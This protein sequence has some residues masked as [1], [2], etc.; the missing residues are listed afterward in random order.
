[1]KKIISLY[2]T[3]ILIFSCLPTLNVVAADFRWINVEVGSPITSKKGDTTYN[4]T[5]ENGVY[6]FSYYVTPEFNFSKT[7]SSIVAQFSQNYL[8]DR[9]TKSTN[10]KGRKMSIY[11]DIS[12][13]EDSKPKLIVNDFKFLDS[14]EIDEFDDT[15]TLKEYIDYIDGRRVFLATNKDNETVYVAFSTKTGIA[16]PSIYSTDTYKVKYGESEPYKGKMLYIVTALEKTI[17]DKDDPELYDPKINTYAGELTK[18]FMQ[19]KNNNTISYIFT[20]S[21]GKKQY[22]LLFNLNDFGEEYY[23]LNSQ[24]TISDLKEVLID[25][26]QEGR[27][28]SVSG[29]IQGSSEN[30]EIIVVKNFSFLEDSFTRYDKENVFLSGE[31]IKIISSELGRDIYLI[32]ENETNLEYYAI[33]DKNVLGNSMPKTMLTNKKITLHGITEL[34]KDKYYIGVLSYGLLNESQSDI[35]TNSYNIKEISISSLQSESEAEILY[36]GI[37]NNGISASYLF[38]K[39]ILQTNMPTSSLLNKTLNVAYTEN[40]EI[41]SVLAWNEIIKEN[42]DYTEKGILLDRIQDSDT[43]VTYNFQNSYGEILQAILTKKMEEDLLT[44]KK[45]NIKT[46]TL[47]DTNISLFGNIVTYQTQRQFIVKDANLLT[48][49]YI[50][51]TTADVF[52][53]NGIL[54]SV[55]SQNVGGI[56]YHAKNSYGQYALLYFSKETLLDNFPINSLLNKN[57]V[58]RGLTYSN[59]IILVTDFN[60]VTKNNSYPHKIE[61]LYEE[62]E[63][64]SNMVGFTGVISL[65]KLESGKT[66]IALITSSQRYLLSYKPAMKDVL[67]SNIGNMVYLRGEPHTVGN[68]VWSGSIDVYDLSPICYT[69]G[70]CNTFIKPVNTPA[71]EY[72]DDGQKKAVHTIQENGQLPEN[73]KYGQ[74]ILESLF[75]PKFIISAEKDFFDK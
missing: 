51:K 31:V 59:G 63:H 30:K 6:V 11:V 44:Q 50:N 34:N 56:T 57:L 16:T 45:L 19:D 13:F 42:Q 18:F 14:E 32:K 40:Q 65:L 17:L 61:P 75:L 64:F 12:A 53:F 5:Y 49:L 71:P 52:T 2:L 54:D 33:F 36:K 55:V 73:Y 68:P 24:T 27:K 74:A 67:E 62:K 72:Q 28:L 22:I 25:E 69:K 39:N 46:E 43:T 66:H 8:G 10:F 23:E 48:E 37:D 20:E 60:E 47:K 4:Y 58:V 7:S 1:M 29:F 15:V 21:N 26:Y 35:T 70:N 38:S 3:I 41:F 9:V